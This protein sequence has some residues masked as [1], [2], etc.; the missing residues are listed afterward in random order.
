SEGLEAKAAREDQAHLDS[1]LSADRLCLRERLRAIVARPLIRDAL[2]VASPDL[3]ES[4]EVWLN[5][6]ESERGSRIER[7]IV[8]Y[9]SR[10]SARA[11]PFGFFAGA[12]VG[13]IVDETRLVIDASER[14]R[15]RS[16][17]D[18]DYLFALAQ[19]AA[20]LPAVRETLRFRPNLSLYRAAGRIHYIEA[21]L[22]GK[23]RTHHLVALE[24][25]RELQGTLARASQ[26]AAFRDLAAGLVNKDV[27]RAEG[28]QYVAELIESQ[29]LRPELHLYLTGPD[30][31]EA[32][33]GQL[34]DYA[35]TAALGDRLETI[36]REI[37][38]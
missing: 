7:A 29:V 26:G 18:M 30:P 12:S 21:R 17:L 36:R 24:D 35:E 10:M 33:A 6:P 37:E 34:R 23:E 19:T 31:T 9:F 32:L 14:N 8:R 15:R 11:T 13:M 38:S 4:L 27:S 28:E 3:D 25:S 2:F 5:E 16:R 20:N 1:A 22:E